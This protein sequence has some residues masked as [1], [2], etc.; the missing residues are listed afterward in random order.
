VDYTA[1]VR[2]TLA[3]ACTHIIE[4]NQHV[5]NDVGYPTDCVEKVLAAAEAYFLRLRELRLEC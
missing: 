5:L 4:I 1:L 2:P 3:R